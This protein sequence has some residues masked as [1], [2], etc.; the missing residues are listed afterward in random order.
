MEV[1]YNAVFRQVISALD[2]TALAKPPQGP[3]PAKS[4][5]PRWRLREEAIEIQQTQISV[6]FEDFLTWITR[7]A[8]QARNRQGGFSHHEQVAA[9]FVQASGSLETLGHSAHM[10]RLESASGW[11]GVSTGCEFVQHPCQECLLL[12]DDASMVKLTVFSGGL[13]HD[14]FLK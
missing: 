13:V 7:N 3:H 5:W 12:T 1:Q 11:S 6:T 14:L 8:F 4:S 9:G 10:D 2:P